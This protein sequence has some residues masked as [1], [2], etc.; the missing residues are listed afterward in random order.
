[1]RAPFRLAAR[2][3]VALEIV[4]VGKMVDARE[5]RAEH[6]AVGGDSPH[7]DAAEAHAVV[8]ALAPDEARAIFNALSTASDP[9]LQKKTWSSEAGAIFAMRSA[10]AKASGWPIWNGGE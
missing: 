1:M 2:E 3:R 5:E 10:S 9:E 7:G 6:L 4:R 8:A